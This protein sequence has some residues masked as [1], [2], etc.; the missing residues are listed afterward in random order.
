[1]PADAPGENFLILSLDDEEKISQ[2]GSVLK[3]KY[4]R[5][6]LKITQRESLNLKEIAKR[7]TGNEKNPR[8]SNATHHKNRLEK[9]GLVVPVKKFKDMH[10]LNFFSGKEVIIIVPEGMK[11]VAEK[12]AKAM[13]HD[14]NV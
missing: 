12:I 9:V 11:G 7:V 14:R 1:M 4:S 8:L 13:L 6:F 10:R 5:E 3:I 2:L